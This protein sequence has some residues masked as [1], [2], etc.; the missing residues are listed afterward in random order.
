M[1]T[2]RT[3]SH[4]RNHVCA[5]RDSDQREGPDEG[6]CDQR[7]VC[8]PDKGGAEDQRDPIRSTVYW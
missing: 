6:D 8:A 7:D 1:E 3:G 4:G 5:R 2:T